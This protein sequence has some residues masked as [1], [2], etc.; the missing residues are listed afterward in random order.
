[1]DLISSLPV[2]YLISHTVHIRIYTAAMNQNMSKTFI[3]L[4]IWIT[5]TLAT[6]VTHA[7]TFITREFL[8]DTCDK[9]LFFRLETSMFFKNNEYFTPYTAG[10]TWPGF[11]LK[12]TLQYYITPTT[13]LSL[14]YYFK[15]FFGWD[16]LFRTT[17]IF[18]IQQRITPNLNLVFGNIYGTE[19]HQIDEPLLRFDRYML[20]HIEYGIQLLYD[21]TTH[22]QS[23]TWLNWE[24][25]IYFN[26]TVQ[27]HIQ[28]G[29]RQEYTFIDQPDI[30][31]TIPLQL[32]VYHR[33]GHLLTQMRI[34]TTANAM[35]GFRFHKPL[36]RHDY[37]TLET[38]MFLYQG[39]NVPDLG[40]NH[41]PFRSGD[42]YY[43]KF[44]Y[45]NKS[46]CLMLGMWMPTKFIA[47]EGEYLMLNAS[48]TYSSYYEFSRFLFTGKFV[49]H[50]SFS[51]YIHVE[52][53]AGFYF[54][55][56]LNN[57]AYYYGLYFTINQPFY[58]GKV[59]PHRVRKKDLVFL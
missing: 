26:S 48:E 37:F 43:L 17:P 13:R 3:R 45:R 34:L 22:F 20:D 8:P 57:L 1:M 29:H 28:F 5:I 11:Y 38:L 7:Q 31:I 58:L 39:L 55:P 32:L 18:T 2:I 33:G 54:D 35:F 53:N 56:W 16:N 23:D 36:A 30:K 40:R 52:V 6:P 50:R 21:D 44:G 10:Y 25:F 9:D 46:M 42:G 14:G 4:I 15:K 19:N 59:N 41:L 24:R 12:P 27:E 49:F 47:P 51:Q